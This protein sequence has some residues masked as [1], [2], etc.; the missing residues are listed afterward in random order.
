ME[1]AV[2]CEEIRELYDDGLDGRLDAQRAA[3]LQAHLASCA[4]CR[5][6]FAVLRSID[7][8]LS[9]EACVSAPP[10]F[11]PSTMAV[12]RRDEARRRLFE[13]VGL[14]AAGATAGGF[15]VASIIRAT[16]SSSVGERI[17]GAAAG[18][19]D[20]V[21]QPSLPDVETPGLVVQMLQSPGVLAVLWTLAAVGAAFMAVQ[22]LRTSRQ[23]A[24][25][26]R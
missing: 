23:L 22:L 3:A 9:T 12:I 18:V 14:W 19:L 21:P 16:R 11:V 17:S 6:E 4:D 8:V 5:R 20:A 10:R 13:R 7:R 1:S 2:R 26:L 24:C 25:E 15:T